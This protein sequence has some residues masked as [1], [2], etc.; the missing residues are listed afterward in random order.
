MNRHPSL[1]LKQLDWSDALNEV[2]DSNMEDIISEANANLILGADLVSHFPFKNL[3]TTFND[4][5]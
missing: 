4:A 3:S 5:S 2:E 1:N